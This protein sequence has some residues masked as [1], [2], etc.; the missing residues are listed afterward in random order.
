MYLSRYHRVR[1][2]FGPNKFGPSLVFDRKKCSLRL[3]RH[4][5]FL[6]QLAAHMCGATGIISF[7]QS[8]VPV[9]MLYNGAG[10]TFNTLPLD[11]AYTANSAGD[12]IDMIR[13]TEWAGRT[14]EDLYL[15]ISSFVGTAANVNDLNI[16]IRNDQASNYSLPDVAGAAV[17]TTS[18][19][20]ASATGWHAVAISQALTQGQTYHI[21]IADADGNG[22]DHAVIRYSQA[23][24]AVAVMAP[25]PLH[26]SDGFST[27]GTRNFGHICVGLV[28]FS[29]GDVLGNPFTA[30]VSPP[31]DANES[32]LRIN[33]GF[34]SQIKLFGVLWTLGRLPFLVYEG[35]TVPGGSTVGGGGN[36]QIPDSVTNTFAGWAVAN[37]PIT[38]SANTPYRIVTD[39]SAGAINAGAYEQQI[40]SGADAV[41]RSAMPGGSNWH[42]TE[43]VAGPAW[44]DETDSFPQMGLL[45]EDF[46]EAPGGGVT[47][48]GILTGGAL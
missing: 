20:P 32:G 16:E 43:E 27:T 33:D 35:S 22:T 25:S 31:F 42:W 9:R 8:N 29:N 48:G 41:L 7:N 24:R 17:A 15:F 26:T 34:T 30:A 39:K 40:G 6:D 10:T 18:F 38:L 11:S 47:R 28:E 3:Y 2:F 21:I 4:K 19:D 1:A 44:N 46:V 14:T 13:Y 12:A 36:H 37:A 5:R 23:G 45:V